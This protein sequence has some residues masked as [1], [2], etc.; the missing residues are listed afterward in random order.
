MRERGAK[1]WKSC[2]RKCRAKV[3]QGEV[4]EGGKD[5]GVSDGGRGETITRRGRSCV[6]AMAEYP[7]QR[8]HGKCRLLQEAG[9]TFLGFRAVIVRNAADVLEPTRDA[10]HG[11]IAA[12]SSLHGLR[13]AS[14]NG[15]L[16]ARGKFYCCMRA[17]DLDQ[18]AN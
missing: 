6:E 3:E 17:A 15:D 8:A 10:L 11:R 7:C 4:V 14:S 13:V 16:R 12:V 18:F 1:P 5:R 2:G 9:S